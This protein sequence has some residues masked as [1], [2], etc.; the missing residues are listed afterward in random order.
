M[1]TRS[2]ATITR[3]KNRKRKPSNRP[4]KR[5]MRGKICHTTIELGNSILNCGMI[6]DRHSIELYM[7]V[8]GPIC[9]CSLSVSLC[10]SLSLTVILSNCSIQLKSMAAL[11]LC[12]VTTTQCSFISVFLYFPTKSHNKYATKTRLIY[13]TAR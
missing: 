11:L 12:T 13:S 3:K 5:T 2:Q 8:R 1:N 4:R 7:S 6:N 9:T 10:L